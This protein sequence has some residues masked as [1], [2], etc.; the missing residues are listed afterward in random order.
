LRKVANKQRN[1]QTDG[2]TNK[3]HYITS[4]VGRNNIVA[5]SKLFNK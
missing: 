3:W 5:G 4:L 1:R 2:Q